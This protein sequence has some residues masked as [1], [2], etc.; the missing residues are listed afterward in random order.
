MH[1][2]SL[3]GYAFILFSVVVWSGWMVVSRHAV[4]GAL[5]AFDVTAIRFTVSGIIMLP[6]AFKRGLRI[7]PWGVWGGVLLALT[8]GA[9]YTT[10]AVMGMKYA[11]ASH[12]STI[13]NGTLLVTTTL[14]GITLLKEPTNVLRLAGVVV[15]LSGM[16]TMLSAKS[17]LAGEGAFAGH[18]L[19]IVSG[20]LWSIYTLLVRHWKADA[21]QAA[22]AVCVL[23]MLLYMPFYLAFAHSNITPEHWQAV[24]LQ[25][26][27]QGVLTAIVALITYNAGIRILG[28]SRAGAFVPLVPALS[29]LLAVP[30]LGEVPGA[31]E[32]I[33][34][35][36]V[37][38]GVLM[39]SG[40]IRLPGAWGR[41]HVLWPSAQQDK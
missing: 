7:G 41:N 19:F 8:V 23:S 27:Y 20:I 22:A 39:A 16:V 35:A 30:F 32:I 9:P 15:S 14:V 28:A 18:M 29:T 26:F 4:K 31:T 13:I 17:T 21:M 37:S 2:Q 38:C 12:A 6:V 36:A 11:P 25:A 1:S 10:L 5:T 34:V 40:V 24:A 3:K 33:G